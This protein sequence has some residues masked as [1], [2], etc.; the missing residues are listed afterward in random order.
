MRPNAAAMHA[1]TKEKKLLTLRRSQVGRDLQTRYPHL[2]C[3]PLN[4]VWEGVGPGSN[5]SGCT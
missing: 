1:E 2:H 4:E 5:L 3:Q